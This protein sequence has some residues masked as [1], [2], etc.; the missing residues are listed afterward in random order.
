MQG[1]SHQE[2]GR[3]H[4]RDSTCSVT[5]I[6][7]HLRFSNSKGLRFM[8]PSFAAEGCSKEEF[9]GNDQ[10]RCRQFLSCIAQVALHQFQSLAFATVQQGTSLGKDFCP[11]LFLVLQ[12]L[13]F[14]SIGSAATG[15]MGGKRH[16]LMN[17]LIDA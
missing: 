7:S 5:G 17:Y 16:L 10:A 13:I 2:T 9:Q 6:D 3:Y 8:V 12:A 1:S 11:K 15:K 4:L 14:L